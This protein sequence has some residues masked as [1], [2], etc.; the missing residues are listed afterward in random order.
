MHAIRLYIRSFL[1]T[2]R[3][4]LPDAFHCLVSN[5]NFQFENAKFDLFG[6]ENASWQ[7]WLQIEI[8]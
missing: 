1:W 3:T 2:L 5:D 6:S 8:G 4:W 7:I